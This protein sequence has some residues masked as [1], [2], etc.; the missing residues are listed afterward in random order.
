MNGE[1]TI[2]KY[3]LEVRGIQQIQMPFGAE[4]LSAQ[5]QHGN[6][7]IWVRVNPIAPLLV[8][9]FAVYG[10]GHQIRDINQTFIGTVQMGSLVWH[11]FCVD[12]RELC[13]QAK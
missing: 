5:N 8:Y 3:V 7:T 2:W 4:I 11:V 9:T 13:A 10:T 1:S 6:L 12:P